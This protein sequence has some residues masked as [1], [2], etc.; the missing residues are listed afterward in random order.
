MFCVVF[1]IY[2]VFYEQLYIKLRPTVQLFFTLFSFFT[3]QK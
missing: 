3:L 2:P 1:L